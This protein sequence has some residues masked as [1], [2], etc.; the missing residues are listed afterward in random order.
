MNKTN[1]IA[2]ALGVL[3][4]GAAAYL[5]FRPAPAPGVAPSGAPTSDAELK[6]ITLTAQIDPVAFDT[7][8]LSDARFTGL[9]DIRTAIVPE[10]S[11]RTDPFAPLAGVAQ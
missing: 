6:F 1:G 11:G 9:Q 5:M 8:I 3:L 10:P 7:S 2:I 4:L